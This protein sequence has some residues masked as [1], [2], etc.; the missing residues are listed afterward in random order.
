MEY[1]FAS[2]TSFDMYKTTKSL[3]VIKNTEYGIY[4]LVSANGFS[5]YLTGKDMLGNALTTSQRQASLSLGLAGILPTAIELTPAS[6][7]VTKDIT[8]KAHERVVRNTQSARSFVD[9]WFNG[10]VSQTDVAMAGGPRLPINAMRDTH[11][12]QEIHTSFAKVTKGTVKP[13]SNMNEFFG[14]KFGKTIKNS[15]SKSSVQYDGQTIY[16]V[17]QKTDSKYLKKGY[18]I[19]LDGLHKDHLEVIDKTGNVKYVLNLDGTLN[20]DK[21]KKALGRVVKGWR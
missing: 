17:T 9:H 11:V 8:K 3:Q 15:L 13:V 4:G 5:E 19:Y 7:G 21:T 14:V 2:V 10:L 20:S 1:L 18:G 12:Q 6:K 16:K